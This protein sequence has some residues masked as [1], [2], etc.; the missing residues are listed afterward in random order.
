MCSVKRCCKNFTKFTGKHL[1][2][3]IFFNK[4]AI[5]LKKRLWHRCFPVNFKKFL[6]TLFLT[7]IKRVDINCIMI[8]DRLLIFE[9]EQ[10]SLAHLKKFSSYIKRCLMLAVYILYG[11]VINHPKVLIAN[12]E[13]VYYQIF[14]NL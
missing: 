10:L 14:F 12:F 8:D 2:P 1:C 7:S 11:P 4:V 6:R 3:S 5:L 9:C 13:Q